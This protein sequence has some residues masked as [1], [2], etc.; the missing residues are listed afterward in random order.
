[1]SDPF[2]GEIRTVG[3]NFAP[4]GWAMCSGQL[5]PISQNTALFSL[6]GTY[7]GGNGTSNFALPNLNGVMVIGQGQGPGLSLR[8]IG[9]IGGASAVSLVQDELPPHTH[10]PIGSTATATSGE[11]QNLTWAEPRLGRA[12][13]AAYAPTPST[14]MAPLGMTGG[15]AAHNNMPPYLAM[16]Y[17]IALQGVYPPRS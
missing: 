16:Y 7:Y 3:F 6:L 10:Q 14:P 13:R 2:V 12:Q 1:M 17:V 15:G 9:E 11:P 8:D 5:I 4:K